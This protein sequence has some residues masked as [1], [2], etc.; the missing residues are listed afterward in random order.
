MGVILKF[1]ATRER[2][3][4]Y[5]TPTSTANPACNSLRE[6]VAVVDLPNGFS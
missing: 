6:T 2:A 4:P 1:F 3:I 5:A